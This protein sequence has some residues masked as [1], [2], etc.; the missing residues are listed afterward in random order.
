M[1]IIASAAALAASFAWACGIVIAHRPAQLVGS[2]EFTRIQLIACGAI[3][4]AL[5]AVLGLWP[6]VAWQHWPA[7]LF[8]IVVGVVL[9][10]LAMVECLRRGGPRRTELL[11]ALRAP[12]VAIT[13]F[14]WLGERLT[15]DDLVG[16]VVALGGVALAI[17]YGRAKE[18]ESDAPRSPLASVILLG[19]AAALCQGIG[20]LVLKPAMEAGTAPLAAAAIRT[21]GAGFLIALLALWP[22]PA[23]RPQGAVTPGL[24][25]RTVL[26]G[27]LGYCVASTL[28][29]YAVANMDAGVATVLGSLSPVMV[30]PLIWLTSGRRPRGAAWIGAA[31]TV[32]GT[33]VILGG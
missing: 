27:V 17:L 32:L 15:P 29:L 2:F 23:F 16:A 12:I 30:L 26:P 6:S 5:S 18:G 7:F 9:G 3:L 1:V 22:S 20:F 19:L 31:L 4:S 11:I 24:L 8:S 21:T 33:G 25:L 28:L 10:N 14:F 13:A